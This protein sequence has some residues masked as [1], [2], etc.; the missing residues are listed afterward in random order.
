[1]RDLPRAH[2]GK[3]KHSR[4][5]LYGLLKFLSFIFDFCWKI[6]LA[7]AETH[8]EQIIRCCFD[9]LNFLKFTSKT[10]VDAIN[11][12]NLLNFFI[13]ENN[14]LLTSLYLASID[15]RGQSMWCMES[16]R[17]RRESSLEWAR[18]FVSTCLVNFFIIHPNPELQLAA[19]A[20]LFRNNDP[21]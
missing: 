14:L 1:M 2:Q 11:K 12:G 8:Q 5:I 10:A 15:R 13:S 6:I 7:S 16:I 17:E 4:W 20:S 9:N 21:N 18:T 3:R 19:A